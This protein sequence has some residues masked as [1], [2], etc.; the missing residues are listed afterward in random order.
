MSWEL[1]V[2]DPNQPSTDTPRVTYTNAAP[3]GIVQGFRWSVRGDGAPLQMRFSAVPA[4]V[5]IGP[6]DIV[7]LIVDGT[8][9]FWGPVTR[10]WPSDEQDVREYIALG[11]VELLRYRSHI[12]PASY[13]EQD[14]AAI[15]RGVVSAYTHPAVIYDAS[16]MPDL[17]DTISMPVVYRQEVGQ[18]L[19]ALA[20]TVSV[21]GVTWGVDSQG[22]AYFGVPSGSIEVGYREADLHWQP[23]VGDE[24]VTRV[25]LVL[26]SSDQGGV[27]NRSRGSAPMPVV[28]SAVDPSDGIYGAQRVYAAPPGLLTYGY[29]TSSS[30]RQSS[31]VANPTYAFDGDPS[32]Y[33]YSSDPSSTY[34][35]LYGLWPPSAIQKHVIGARI[36]YKFSSDNPD[37]KMHF[38]LVWEQTHEPYDTRYAHATLPRTGSSAREAHVLLLPPSDLDWGTVYG[39]F[40]AVGYIKD[41]D[42][43]LYEIDWLYVDYGRAAEYARSLLKPPTQRP[44]SVHWDRYQAPKPRVTVTDA[45]GGD[46][47]HNVAEWAYSWTPRRLDTIAKLGSR[48]DDDLTTAINRVAQ[49]NQAGALATA[50]TL[51]ETK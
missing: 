21:K 34:L 32:T 41:D 9:A 36:A 35:M 24:V 28:V 31:S 8:P 51:T 17:G 7:Q 11:G 6:R 49:L 2:W 33:A 18:I 27:V 4:G 48:A 44:A 38:E 39:N 12:D 3:G 50:R 5:D 25:D 15:A 1:R 45:P 40:Y 16:L 30:I 26:A 47:T 13:S 23:E 20:R 46:L 19:D 22:Y 43:R 37:A 10:S 29:G 42:W 14:V